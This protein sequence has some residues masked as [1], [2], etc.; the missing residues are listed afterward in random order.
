[1]AKATDLLDSVAD[2]Q[3]I[4]KFMEALG[5][6][7]S[8]QRFKVGQDISRNLEGAGIKIP[9]A[10]REA[11]LVFESH[12]SH[13]PRGRRQLVLITPPPKGT[14]AAARIRL[15]CISTT[16]RGHDVWI[17]LECGWLYC[18]IVIYF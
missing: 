6:R 9:K 12:E 4:Q 5:K 3:D 16:I 2:L 13:K 10:L 1:M 17:C 14:A 18:M 8:D 15:I 11:P 7:V